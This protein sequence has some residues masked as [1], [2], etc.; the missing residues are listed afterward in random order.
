MSTIHQPRS[1]SEINRSRPRFLLAIIGP[2]VCGLLVCGAEAL[3][4]DLYRVRPRIGAAGTTV[5]LVLQGK[6]LA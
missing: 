6:H 1:G 5:E 2:V 4:N 3:A